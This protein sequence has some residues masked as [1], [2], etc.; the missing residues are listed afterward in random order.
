MGSLVIEPTYLSHMF[1][2]SF[3]NIDPNI[4]TIVHRACGAHLKFF[5]A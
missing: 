5:V 1:A 3:N 4:A 2:T